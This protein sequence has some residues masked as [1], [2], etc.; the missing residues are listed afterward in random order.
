MRDL[1]QSS[2][3]RPIPSRGPAGDLVD[4]AF[5]PAILQ[6]RTA[7]EHGP[8]DPRGQGGA[9]EWIPGMPA[10]ESLAWH[11]G[12]RFLR[13]Q[14]ARRDPSPGQGPRLGDRSRLRVTARVRRAPLAPGR[15]I[16]NAYD[17]TCSK[18]GCARC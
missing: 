15:R 5:E 7:A 13:D 2:P 18:K 11:A 6:V 17:V 9:D 4:R 16:E 1:L 3:V 14:E 8:R 10:H 12:T